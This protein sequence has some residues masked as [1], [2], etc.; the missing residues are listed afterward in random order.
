M[1]ARGILLL[2]IYES[3]LRHESEEHK[4]RPKYFW[5]KSMRVI[6][7]MFFLL[8]CAIS[9]NVIAQNATGN[10]NGKCNEVVVRDKSHPVWKALDAQY[11][12]IAEAVRKRNL[13][14]LFALYMPDFQAK[15]PNGEIWN[16]E[17]LFGYLRNGLP[18]VKETLHTSNT[19]LR[20]VVCGEDQATATVLQQWYR[21][22]MVAGKPRRLETNAVQDEHRVKTPDGRKLRI[23]DEIRDGAGFLDGKRV[24]PKKPLDPEAPAYDPYDPRPKQSVADALFSIITDKGIESALRSYGALKQSN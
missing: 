17:I 22:Q 13:D 2:E 23:V 3:S 6:L 10:R 1:S 8:S 21:T 9:S 16:R 24:D 5:E 15:Q 12:K 14:A 11:A 20:L 4:K 7:V 18:R 19:I